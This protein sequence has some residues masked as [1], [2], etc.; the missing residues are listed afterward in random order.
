M[1]GD[2]SAR[3]ESNGDAA[4]ISN[5]WGDPGGKSY[6]AYQL[7]S[8]SGSLRLFVDWLQRR[9]PLLGESLAKYPLCSDEFDAAWRDVASYNYY[10]FLT[11]QH[12]YIRDAYYEPA[13]QQLAHTGW[14][15]DNHNPIMQD[16]VWSR[17][18]QY[19]AG[20]IVEMFTTAAHRMYNA[21]DREYTGYPNLSYID[22]A[23]FDYD[24]ITAIYLLVCKTP[25]WTVSSLRA[26]LYDRFEREC[27]D[28]LAR[29]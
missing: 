13:V 15:I 17:A 19:G 22:A 20:N 29:L 16:V 18:V 4:C 14:H 24:F 21:T 5:G 8:N 26:S 27:H 2:L 6:G 23:Q 12:E 25:E 3:Y 28:A 1:L 11:A 7:S 9:Y 10:D